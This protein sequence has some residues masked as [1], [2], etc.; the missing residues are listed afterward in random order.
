MC[1]Y[2]VKLKFYQPKP[3]LLTFRWIFWFNAYFC[4]KLWKTSLY[5]PVSTAQQRL[6]R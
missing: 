4:K 5:Q 3:E 1:L 6:T 2:V